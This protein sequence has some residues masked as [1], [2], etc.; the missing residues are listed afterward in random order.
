MLSNTT[1]SCSRCGSTE[2][3]IDVIPAERFKETYEVMCRNCGGYQG[4]LDINV[5]ISLK[6][7]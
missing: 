4:E 7:A 3:A 5:R 6:A 2:F 1:Y